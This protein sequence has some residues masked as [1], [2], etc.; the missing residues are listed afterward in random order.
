MSDQIR[1]NRAI[2]QAERCLNI[3][4]TATMQKLDVTN[5][6]LGISQPFRMM[7]S[8]PTLVGI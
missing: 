6:F 2:A 7:I 3:S 5:Q 4:E 1:A 8:G